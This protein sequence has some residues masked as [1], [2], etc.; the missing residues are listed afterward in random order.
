[1]A[2]DINEFNSR[3]DHVIVCGYSV[4]GKFVAKHLDELDVP[5]VIIDNSPKHVSEAIANAK[6]AYLGDMSKTS[7][8]EAI[9]AEHSAAIIVTLDN[10]DKKRAICEA[11]A[12]YTK[13]INLIVKIA[14]LEDKE[15]LKGLPITALIDSKLEVS[16]VLVERMVTCQ[17]KYR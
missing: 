17:L 15:S 1:M 16:R 13:N 6:E 10:I 7:L 11:V 2:L 8:L 5:Y 12:K 9:N 14:S 4:V 3:K